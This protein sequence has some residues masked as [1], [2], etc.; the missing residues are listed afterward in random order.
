M[1][2]GPNETGNMAQITWTEP[3]PSGEVRGELNGVTWFKITP[4]M[5]EYYSIATK[6]PQPVDAPTVVIGLDAAKDQ[7]QASLDAYQA[8]AQSLA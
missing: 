8:L 3:T 6:I 4:S 2:A 5:G 1:H 7:L